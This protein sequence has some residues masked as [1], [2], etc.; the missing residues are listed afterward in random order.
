VVQAV[1]DRGG[2]PERAVGGH[3]RIVEVED[4][5]TGRVNQLGQPS[6]D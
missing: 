1:A 6:L 4:E 5:S 3:D 2:S